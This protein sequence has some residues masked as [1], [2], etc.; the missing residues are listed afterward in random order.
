MIERGSDRIGIK[1][2]YK[3]TV[4]PFV[5]LLFNQDS[6]ADLWQKR[7]SKACGQNHSH[8]SVSLSRKSQSPVPTSPNPQI[9]IDLSF[10][11][12]FDFSF[13]DL[14]N[15]NS[16]SFRDRLGFTD[17]EF[18]KSLRTRFFCK[19]WIVDCLSVYDSIVEPSHRMHWFNYGEPFQHLGFLILD[20]DLKVRSFRE[21]S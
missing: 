13:P 21:I 17:S 6:D 10:T 7:Y 14:K 9:P 15:P 2:E 20:I 1:G 8:P 18:E 11:R 3:G 16:V 5:V 19:Y 12:M 4:H